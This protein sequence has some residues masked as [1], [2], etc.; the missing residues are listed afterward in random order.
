M[1]SFKKRPIKVL[2]HGEFGF[3]TGF[4]GVSENILDRLWNIKTDWGTQKFGPAVM[5]LGQQVNPFDNN[6]KK[7]YKVIP[8]YGNRQ[9]APYGQDYAADLVR[10]FKPD[11]VVSFGDT[12][13]VDFW[14]D[15][16]AIPADLRK[17]FKLVGYVAIDGYPIPKDWINKYKNFDKLITFT[18]FGE[19]TVLERAKQVGASLTVSQ[20]YHG[21]DNQ[22]F[23]PLPRKD[24]DE[25]K[26]QRGLEGKK[27]IGMFSRNQPRKHH[28]EFIEAAREILNRTN[29]PDIMFYFHTVERDA[30]WSLP[31]LID[32]VDDLAMRDRFLKHGTVGPNQESPN[33]PDEKLKSRIFFPGITN[34]AEGMPIHMLNMMYNICD[35]HVLL[36]SGEGFGCTLLESMAAGI[37]TFT[38]DY[39]AGAELVKLAGQE[40][41]KARAYSYRG[42]DHNFYRPHTDYDDLMEKVIP[43]L[44]DEEVR[45]KYSKKAKAFA[46]GMSWDIIND[47]WDREL[48]SLYDKDITEIE[49]NAEVM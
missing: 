26:K 45:K 34:P 24:V 48:S 14:N 31:D 32:D 8:M 29:D 3:H 1:S 22:I 49:Q 39:A 36:T 9:A 10:R 16:G 35:V 21:V 20:I 33:T 18:K 38:N 28:P 30:G 46:M 47:D 13:M 40:V 41:F 6:Q 15:E 11:I 7:P 12:W 5:A 17:T 19:E 25:F 27:I 42:S 23:K 37:P 4:A 2:W 44:N 43:V